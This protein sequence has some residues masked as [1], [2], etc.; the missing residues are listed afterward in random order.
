MV[1]LGAAKAQGR[2]KECFNHSVIGPKLLFVDELGYLSFGRDEANLF[3]TVVARSHEHGSMTLTS[4]WTYTQL[5]T[6]M[7]DDQTLTAA[8]A[9]VTGSRTD[10]K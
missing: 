3:F 7:V 1:R 10:A 8:A 2:L 6:A 4:N 9:R 5:A